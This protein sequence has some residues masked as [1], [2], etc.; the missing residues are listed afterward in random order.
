MLSYSLAGTINNSINDCKLLRVNVKLAV[1]V[2]YAKSTPAR[3]S[4]IEPR[5][6]PFSET[7]SNPDKSPWRLPKYISGIFK[8]QKIPLRLFA[9]CLFS[10]C[11]AH[12]RFYLDVHQ[13]LT[14]SVLIIRRQR[15]NNANLAR[16]SRAVLLRT[17]I[18]GERRRRAIKCFLFTIN[19]SR[20]HRPHPSFRVIIHRPIL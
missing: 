9:Q 10:R 3:K 19:V 14:L 7:P 18:D 8:P 12:R 13:R 5:D 4:L 20:Y 15:L 11:G 6:S 16:I 17:A 2:F 1:I